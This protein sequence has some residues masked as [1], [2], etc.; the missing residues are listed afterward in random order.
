MNISVFSNANQSSIPVVK[1]RFKAVF[2]WHQH[3]LQNS[4]YH[5]N[6]PSTRCFIVR[7][8]MIKATA[9]DLNVH[10]SDGMHTINDNQLVPALDAVLYRQAPPKNIHVHQVRLA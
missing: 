1:Y 2:N 3:W 10:S 5:M 4:R 8:A 7:Q 6:I 9:F